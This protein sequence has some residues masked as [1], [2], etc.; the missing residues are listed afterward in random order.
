MV[1]GRENLV[2]GRA[3]QVARQHDVQTE[4][5]RFAIGE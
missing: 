4:K 3:Q 1:V 2:E 5:T